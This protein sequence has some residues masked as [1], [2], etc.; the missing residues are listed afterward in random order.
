MKA[1]AVAVV[2]FGGGCKGDRNEPRRDPPGA[3]AP[4]PARTPTPEPVPD[5]CEMQI[6]IK[7]G[8]L[9]WRVPSRAGGIRFAGAMGDGIVASQVTEAAKQAWSQYGPC[10]AVIRA[11]D[12][13]VY[14]D[15]VTVM[16]ALV[17]GNIRDLELDLKGATARP[18]RKAAT[19]GEVRSMS[20]VAVA[21]EAVYLN[22]LELGKLADPNLDAAL[23]A[24]YADA[25]KKTPGS[26]IVLQADRAT[27][28]ANLARVVGAARTAG[29]TDVLFA[30]QNQ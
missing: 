11:D 15:V 4:A 1:I 21:P 6:E 12:K 19:G 30:V 20:I 29:F 10:T 2:L 28:W 25:Q 14:Q 13:V 22:G 7:G 24:A 17:L 16:D 3:P 5:E 8:G 23:A 9:S 26:Q 27:T 18:P